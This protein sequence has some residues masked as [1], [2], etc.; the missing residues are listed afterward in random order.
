MCFCRL[1]KRYDEAFLSLCLYALISL[2]CMCFCVCLRVC[3]L[4]FTGQFNLLK[5][6]VHPA[7][8]PAL[9]QALN[10]STAVCLFC[11]FVFISV[12]I[13]SSSRHGQATS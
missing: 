2:L 13:L 9:P 1:L 12:S 6:Y 3:D 7:L 8:P 10:L 11:F 4:V 5:I